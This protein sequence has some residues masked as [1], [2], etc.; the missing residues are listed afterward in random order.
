MTVSA[1]GKEVAI[2]VVNSA[3]REVPSGLERAGGHYGLAAM[4][5]RVTAC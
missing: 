2:S 5:E 3:A 4:R 1:Q